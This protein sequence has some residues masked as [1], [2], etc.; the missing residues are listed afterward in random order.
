MSSTKSFSIY[1]YELYDLFR[2]LCGRLNLPCRYDALGRHGCRPQSLADATSRLLGDAETMF[3]VQRRYET[4]YRSPQ[5]PLWQF[6]DDEWLKILR[7]PQVSKRKAPPQPE[8][9]QERLFA[10]T[11]RQHL[12]NTCD[13]F[14]VV[15][16]NLSSTVLDRLLRCRVGWCTP[17]GHAY[18][19]SQTKRT[20]RA[21]DTT[22][23]FVYLIG[24][25]P[26]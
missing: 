23:T 4:P 25:A 19:Q 13:H 18:A 1:Q 10:Y 24:T 26:V 8:A 17:T 15:D 2:W 22:R 21:V 20:D 3:N 5:L 6:G 16:G 7:L 12:V 9:A 14:D 11:Y